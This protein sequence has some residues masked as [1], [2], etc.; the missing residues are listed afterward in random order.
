M[1]LRTDISRISFEELDLF[2]AMH[3]LAT[4][5]MPDRRARVSCVAIAARVNR[6]E[7][8][9]NRNIERLP[10]CSISFV[11]RLAQ[12]H[13]KKI[14]HSRQAIYIENILYILGLMRWRVL[15]KYAK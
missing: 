4:S 6:E 9:Q 5:A 14:Q 2:A 10:S 15:Y 13:E 12:Q 1:S 8:S 3:A 7:I 11:R